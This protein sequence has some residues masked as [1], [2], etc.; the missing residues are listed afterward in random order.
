MKNKI[1]PTSKYDDQNSIL[2]FNINIINNNKVKRI[3]CPTKVGRMKIYIYFFTN[4]LILDI[5]STSYIAQ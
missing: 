5:L 1:K 3:N 4:S 2:T